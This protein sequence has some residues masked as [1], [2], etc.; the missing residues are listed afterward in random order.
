MK[1]GYN[2]WS[3]IMVVIGLFLMIEPFTSLN[4]ILITNWYGFIVGCVIY[5]IGLITGI[6]AFK[7]KE[8]GFLKYLSMTSFLLA[9]GWICYMFSFIGTV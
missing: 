3:F 1:K 2:L 8:R 6:V 5:I 9:V 4:L 7:R